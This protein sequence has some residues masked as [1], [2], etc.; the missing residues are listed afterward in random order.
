MTTRKPSTSKPRR[1][2][3]KRAGSREDLEA[4]SLRPELERSF[5]PSRVREAGF[6]GGETPERRDGV[7][8][9]DLSPSTLI[10]EAGGGDP[11]DLRANQASD[12]A[13]SLVDASAV[14]LG[15]G[16]DEAEDARES[17]ISRAE[18]RRLQRRVARAGTDPND[19]EPA[20]RGAGAPGRERNARSH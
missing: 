19:V 13:L 20:E 17:P 12:T 7:T 5:P 11:G 16:T 15:G 4:V 14:G 2:P 10:D 1:A 18:H 6:T 3:P 9:D 8:A